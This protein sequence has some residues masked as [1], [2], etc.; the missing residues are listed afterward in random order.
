MGKGS[1][2]P[3]KLPQ[4]YPRDSGV[5]KHKSHSQR[6]LQIPTSQVKEKVKEL[7]DRG[8]MKTVHMEHVMNC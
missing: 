4:C 1:S 8:E 7:R 5:G 6:S 3:W 2:A